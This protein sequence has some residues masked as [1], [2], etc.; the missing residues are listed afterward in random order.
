MA[1][2]ADHLQRFVE[3]VF[4]PVIIHHRIALVVHLIQEMLELVIIGQVDIEG[5]HQ[6][7]MLVVQFEAFL[8]FSM[9]SKTRSA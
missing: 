8:V 3:R 5:L 1:S 6:R 4:L 2:L 7:H 9:L